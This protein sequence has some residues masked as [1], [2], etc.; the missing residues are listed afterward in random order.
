MRTTRWPP[1]ILVQAVAV[2]LYLAVAATGTLSE[3][4]RGLLSCALMLQ[5]ALYA[6]RSAVRVA[7]RSPCGRTRTAWRLL[8][9]GCFG[10]A[11]TQAY[12]TALEVLEAAPPTLLG[13]A[14]MGYASLPLLALPALRLLVVPAHAR[15][16]AELRL[17]DLVAL[18]GAVIILGWALA[19]DAALH[20]ER[21]FPVVFS[22]GDVAI[23][24]TVIGLLTRFAGGVG[25][26][27]QL[28]AAGLVT[29]AATDI[30]Y[31]GQALHGAYVTG[32][33]LDAGWM[34]GFLLLA[35]SAHEAAREARE[36]TSSRLARRLQLL[37]PYLP[38]ALA[39]GLTG[40]NSLLGQQAPG[41]V[42]LA[43]AVG[44]VVVS[45]LRQGLT[46]TQNADLID[47]LAEREV[48]LRR[49]ALEDPL[50]G[51]GNRTLLLERLDEAL[52]D[53]DE[54]VV[55]LLYVDLDDFKLINDTHG[56]EAG[57]GV[58]VEV[59]RRLREITGPGDTVARLGG[60][61][62][63][64]LVLGRPGEQ[65]AERVLEVLHT[66]VPVGSRR[67]VV[68]GSIGLVRAEAADETASTLMSH[69]TSRCT[70]PRAR[71][72]A[73]CR[74][75]TASTAPAPC[76]R[77]GCASSSRTPG[78]RTCAFSTSRWWT[79]ATAPSAAWRPSCAGT[80]LRWARCP[81]RSSSTSPSRPGRSARSATTCCARR[82]TTSPAGARPSRSSGWPSA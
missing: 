61:E 47:E 7:T 3:P 37:L 75:C 33:W 16:G 27:L 11:L 46:L 81:P 28:A 54:P 70:P 48:D 21:L 10:W 41:P 32:T 68:N 57:D 71:A 8:A 58:L 43:L 39:T 2:V 36:S 64:V 22:V 77:R 1:G 23:A 76:A 69:A 25:R 79:C 55:A 26:P 74:R 40:S 35:A 29:V 34:V 15:R 5:I 73:A 6:G 60:D 18:S 51:L 67:F 12:W 42:V 72:R 65:V 66:P 31:V 13:V 45:V 14:G 50:T 82:C 52:R 24:I 9:T 62:F 59:A 49:R 53:P 44:V 38:I 17:L 30:T 63:A 4:Q 19:L 78:P 80:T 20:Q 56:H